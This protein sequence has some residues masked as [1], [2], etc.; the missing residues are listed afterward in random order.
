M[1]QI[2]D[3]MQTPPHSTGRHRK[4]KREEEEEFPIGNENLPKLDIKFVRE[5]LWT[6][7]MC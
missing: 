7:D 4:K 3:Q 6:L 1:W 5:L 2:P